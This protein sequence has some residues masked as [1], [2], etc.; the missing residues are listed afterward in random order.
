VSA[1]IAAAILVAMTALRRWLRSFYRRVK[2]VE[3]VHDEQPGAGPVAP[4]VLRNLSPG[5]GGPGV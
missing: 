5:G 1:V 4:D 2:T 3:P